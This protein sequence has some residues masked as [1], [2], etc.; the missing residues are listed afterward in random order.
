MVV[1]ASNCLSYILFALNPLY[2]GNP[3]MSI[4]QTVKTQMKWSIKLHFI[5]VYIVCKGKKDL[6]K[7]EHNIF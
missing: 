4:L 7:K 1:Q 5:R 3:I 6:Q 2:L